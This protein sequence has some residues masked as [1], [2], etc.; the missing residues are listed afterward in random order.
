MLSAMRKDRT[1]AIDGRNTVL[2]ETNGPMRESKC[3]DL[4]RSL[5]I[6]EE[7]VIL[8]HHSL[9]V[10]GRS[11]LETTPTHYL[12]VFANSTANTSSNKDTFKAS[13]LKT[14]KLLSSQ[15]AK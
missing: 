11:T 15:K 14:S 1:D 9:K 4:R 6:L 12:N 8:A 2:T 13:T 7:K 3:L 10:D 5:D